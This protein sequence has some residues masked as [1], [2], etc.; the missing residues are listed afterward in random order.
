M[1]A[2]VFD[3]TG[4]IENLQIRDLPPPP[5]IRHG[6]VRIKF[7]AGSLN[8][9]DLW[10]L[11][12][13]PRV[14]YTFPHIVGADLCGTVIES[15]SMRFKAGERVILYPAQCESGFT[16]ENLAPD[17]E[18]RGENMG[19][20]FAE[21]TVVSEK[22]VFHPPSHLND[23]E[24]AALPLVYLTA[25]QM[26]VEKAGMKSA[27]N[28]GPVV[29]HAAGSGVSQAL[30]ELLLSFKIPR[31]ATTSRDAQ[32]LAPWTARGVSGFSESDLFKPL[33]DW[34]GTQ[35][36]A[37]VFDHVGEA[38][39]DMNIKLLR[40]GGKL[41]TCGATSG[42]AAKL[43]LRHLYFRQLQLLGSTMG[44]LQDFRDMLEWV[45]VHG[46]KPHISHQL[47]FNAFYEAF[48]AMESGGQSGKIVLTL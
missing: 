47:P 45:S 23:A 40:S 14:K 16:P 29:V 42:H 19:G 39:F 5:A 4:A 7:L 3:K 10:V 46:I 21:E 9:L 20:V 31:I 15:K 12:G 11:K 26:A 17:F 32:K 33:K 38:Y 2:I 13:L 28:S 43:D 6:E 35:K 34:A 48:S 1:K 41:V 25:W 36:V 8:H 37:V 30:L 22:Y 24:A 44:S 27:K 18:I